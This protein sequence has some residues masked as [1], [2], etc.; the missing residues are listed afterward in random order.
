MTVAQE[1]TE[2]EATQTNSMAATQEATM[3]ATQ[4]ASEEM[5]RTVA[6]FK[7]R[8]ELK[9]VEFLRDNELLCNKRIT[10]YKNLG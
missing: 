4:E 6:V 8:D 7:E 5:K 1:A 10:D 9:L 2:G 3:E